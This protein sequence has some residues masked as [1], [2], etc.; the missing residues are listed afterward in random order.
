MEEVPKRASLR[1]EFVLGGLKVEAGLFKVHGKPPEVPEYVTAGPNG[2]PLRAEQKVV[3]APEGSVDE[4][5]DPLGVEETEA[6]RSDPGEYKQ[7]LVE[8]K[9]GV[10][11]EKEDVRRG[12]RREDGTF[13]DLTDH[14][15]RI[16]E[17]AKLEAVEVLKFIDRRRVPR[18]RIRSAYYVALGGP[19][20]LE[21]Q[22]TLYEAMKEGNRVAVV[23]WTKRSGQTLGILTP[24]P[25]GAVEILEL[26]WHA[27]MRAPNAECL[28]HLHAQVTRGEVD[29][30]REL[31]ESMAGKR[32]DL[33]AYEDRRWKALAELNARAEAGELDDYVMEP[34]EVEEEMA[35]L[36]R[37]LAESLP[38]AA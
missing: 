22:R 7:V 19:L 15:A 36:E 31:I 10:E 9:S 28:A 11:V 24:H 1:T 27:E 37:L 12:V 13:V 5:A 17:E 6:P 38:S 3:R 34:E 8:E 16:E 32:V 18:D 23:R 4:K 26:A 35:S 14:L 29:R 20:G 25:S 30:A 21:L 33:D 2:H